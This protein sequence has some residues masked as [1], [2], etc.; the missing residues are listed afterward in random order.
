MVAVGVVVGVLALSAIVALVLR[1]RTT[2]EAPTQ[3]AQY[4]VP[5]QLDRAD[6]ER[7]D[8]PWLVVVFTSATCDACAS[9]VD[10]AS[11]LASEE[12]AVQAVEFSADRALHERY[13]IEAVPM[14]L[15]ADGDGVV[16]ASFLGSPSAADL[17]AA[18]AALRADSD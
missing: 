6:F 2:V 13:D 7:P 4:G 10:K 3:P 8:A 5:V 16:R 15:V 11:V 17:W 14:L 1:R 12:V 18:V 9:V